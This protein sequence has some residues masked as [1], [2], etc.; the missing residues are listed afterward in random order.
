M[1]AVPFPRDSADIIKVGLR[2]IDYFR[3][4][5]WPI[6]YQQNSSQS[7]NYLVLND[8]F[9]NVCRLVFYLF[10]SGEKITNPEVISRAYAFSPL[11]LPQQLLLSL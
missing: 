5:S 7:I 9:V 11:L 6:P 3:K 10:S 4:T 2:E 8:M 1:D